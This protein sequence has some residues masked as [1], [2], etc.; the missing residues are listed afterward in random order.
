VHWHRF[1]KRRKRRTPKFVAAALLLIAR[2]A[3]ADHFILETQ[4]VLLPQEISDLAAHGVEYSTC[5]RIIAI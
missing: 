1:P 2:A 5:C 3:F 4:H